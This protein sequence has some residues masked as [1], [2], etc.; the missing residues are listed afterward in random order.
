MENNRH[1]PPSEQ[2]TPGGMEH[3]NPNTQKE[4]IK[5]IK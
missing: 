4:E 2:Q 5:K 1:K 3:N